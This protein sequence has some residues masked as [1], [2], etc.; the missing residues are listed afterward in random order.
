MLASPQEAWPT[1]RNSLGGE[2]AGILLG[3]PALAE[4]FPLQRDH[5]EGAAG[6]TDSHGGKAVLREILTALNNEKLGGLGVVVVRSID[7]M[8]RPVEGVITLEPNNT[9]LVVGIV[10]VGV[11]R[12]RLNLNT[13]VVGLSNVGNGF[14][15]LG[16]DSLFINDGIIPGPDASVQTIAGLTLIC[17]SGRAF[18][19]T[20]KHT[21]QVFQELVVINGWGEVGGDIAVRIEGCILADSTIGVSIFGDPL[22]LAVS[23]SQFTAGV[24]SSHTLIDLGSNVFSQSVRIANCQLETLSGNIALSGLVDNGNLGP[25][26]QALVLLTD[27]IGPGVFF[28]NI[29]LNDKRWF[30]S[31]NF[32][33]NNSRI[34]GSYGMSDNAV[35]TPLSLGVLTKIAGTTVG[36]IERRM[37]HVA[38]NR[39]NYEHVNPTILEIA[40]ALSADKPVASVSTFEFCVCKNGGP[41]AG[42]SVV[43]RPLQKEFAFAPDSIAFPAAD[44]DAKDGDHY[45]VFVINKTHSDD[46]LVTDMV[47]NVVGV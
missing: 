47:V 31:A 5:F 26:S 32:G 42:G 28:N 8:P 2:G 45:A 43:G 21:A 25:N 17:S 39:M 13:P 36:D 27:F 33:I 16:T 3:M 1:R 7:D 40:V 35:V 15:Y 30:F 41:G 22:N 11:T 18:G 44:P 4:I 14:L 19:F 34:V 12:I 24:S 37:V 29:T 9:Y 38:S 6:I 20:V 10:N 23:S 46:L